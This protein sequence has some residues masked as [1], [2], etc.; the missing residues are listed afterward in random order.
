MD[1]K[2]LKLRHPR[3]LSP[4]DKKSSRIERLEVVEAVINEDVA[5]SRGSFEIRMEY[6]FG[7]RLSDYRHRGFSFGASFSRIAGSAKIT[8]G[9]IF[10]DPD[11]LRGYGLGTYA[12]DRVVQWV[13]SHAPDLT[14]E[15]ITLGGDNSP[16]NVERR[17][18]FYENCGVVFEN[19]K[20]IPMKVSELKR[21]HPDKLL[22]EVDIPSLLENMAEIDKSLKSLS[23]VVDFLKEEEFARYS[24]KR[25]WF[26]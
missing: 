11:G 8:N 9:G 3:A 10:V 2:F 1:R 15:T 19:S 24:K 7:W 16:D 5:S 21:V 23:N 13:Q 14:V 25:F 17:R 12:M 6:V 26:F 4:F 18:K 22:S 20:S